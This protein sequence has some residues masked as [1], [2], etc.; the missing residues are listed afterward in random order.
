MM[1]ARQRS[2]I[3]LSD[4]ALN[5]RDLRRTISVLRPR[6]RKLDCLCEYTGEVVAD[7]VGGEYANGRIRRTWRVTHKRT[8]RAAKCDFDH[9][10]R[11]CW[12]ERS[13]PLKTTPIPAL[14]ICKV[15]SNA[16]VSFA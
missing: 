10:I 11:K 2:K 16:Y 6:V 4:A 13:E 15:A 8:S 7:G 3:T 12:N 1:N 9:D 14:F 5:V